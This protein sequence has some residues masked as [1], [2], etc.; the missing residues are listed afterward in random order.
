MGL[1]E[2]ARRTRTRV[3]NSRSNTQREFYTLLT[4]R[5]LTDAIAAFI[6]IGFAL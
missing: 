4:P 3:S 1:R 2:F 5:E 6:E